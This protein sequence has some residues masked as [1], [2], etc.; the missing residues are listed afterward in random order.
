MYKPIETPWIGAWV[1]LAQVDWTFDMSVAQSGGSWPAPYT[2]GSA[3]F[4]SRPA[5]SGGAEFPSWVN[6]AKNFIDPNLNP[7]RP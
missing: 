7:E 2:G 5:P 6:S 3:T 4:N 1:A